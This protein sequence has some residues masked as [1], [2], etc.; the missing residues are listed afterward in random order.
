MAASLA[1]LSERRHS[2]SRASG[3]PPSSAAAHGTTRACGTKS[4]A[5]ESSASRS[6]SPPSPPSPAAAT[7]LSETAGS[8]EAAYVRRRTTSAMR[9]AGWRCR[10]RP[11]L[12]CRSTAARCGPKRPTAD[13]ALRPRPRSASIAAVRRAPS[14]T[15]TTSR[16]PA[17]SVS[18]AP[19][20]KLALAARASATS[21][22]MASARLCPR[23]ASPS[24]PPP[25]VRRLRRTKSAARR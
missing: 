10:F 13:A 23:Q 18:V 24:Q 4:T 16:P 21:R 20:P 2:A 17:L 1:A 8:R 25:A 15:C 11:S 12:A 22:R 14:P 7:W 5:L 9:R 19:S 6:A 3:E